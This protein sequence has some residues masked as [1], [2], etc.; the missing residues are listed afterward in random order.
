MIKRKTYEGENGVRLSKQILTTQRIESIEIGVLRHALT[1]KIIQNDS[2]MMQN[3]QNHQLKTCHVQ[4][5]EDMTAERHYFLRK[6]LDYHVMHVIVLYA[7]NHN[8]RL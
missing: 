7:R 5:Q 8:F 6:V 3:I 4:Q 2:A 1:V